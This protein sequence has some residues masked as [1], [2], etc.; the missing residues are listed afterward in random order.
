MGFSHVNWLFTGF[1]NIE[2]VIR[3]F[4]LVSKRTISV[5]SGYSPGTLSVAILF[6]IFFLFHFCSILSSANLRL[7]NSVKLVELI[8]NLEGE[9]LLGSKPTGDIDHVQ[10][11]DIKV[12]LTATSGQ[13]YA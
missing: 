11:H 12:R 8:L 7:K 5:K 13:E 1:R 4:K 6:I 10:A 2:K 3:N 9:D